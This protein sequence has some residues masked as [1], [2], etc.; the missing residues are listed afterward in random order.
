MRS[1]ETAQSFPLSSVK[2]LDKIAP[3]RDLCLKATRRLLERSGRSRAVSPV[4]GKALQPLGEVEGLP[5]GLCAETGS[6]FLTKVSGPDEWKGL[7]GE[8]SRSRRAPDGLGGEL[9]QSRA[10]NVYAPKLDWIRET[11]T[12][13]GVRKARVL[14]AATPPSQMRGLLNECGSFAEVLTV[15]E[16]DLATAHRKKRAGRMPW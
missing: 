14:E 9:S 1:I 16:M 5:Y 7:L 3:L 4:T 8:L 6:L 12:L 15:D 2:P 13:Q 10:D 11:L